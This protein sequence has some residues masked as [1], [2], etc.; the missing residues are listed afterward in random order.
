MV[1]PFTRQREVLAFGY[2]SDGPNYDDALISICSNSGHRKATVFGLEREAEEL[3]FD[4]FLCHLAAVD[5]VA[6]KVVVPE[7]ADHDAFLDVGFERLYALQ[8][9]AVH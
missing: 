6:L 2:V 5:L 9:L 4:T 7:C 8:F 1:D 3:P